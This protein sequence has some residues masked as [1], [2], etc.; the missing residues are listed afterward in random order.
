MK[1]YFW[2]L[3]SGLE[4]AFSSALNHR[5]S[6]SCGRRA[7]CDLKHTLLCKKEN[8][9]SVFIFFSSTGN[10]ELSLGIGT[11][12]SIVLPKEYCELSFLNQLNQLKGFIGTKKTVGVCLFCEICVV[13]K[14]L[15]LVCFV[16]SSLL[17]SLFS[18]P[19]VNW[20][21]HRTRELH[22]FNIRL[23]KVITF[24]GKLPIILM[25]WCIS[26]GLVYRGQGCNIIHKKCYDEENRAC[27]LCW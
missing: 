11:L 12:E 26:M 22:K 5:R 13:L 10:E 9:P 21:L 14:K 6:R 1:P 7:V 20:V 27:N 3:S 24:S 15:T 25:I 23:A 2:R 4:I 16:V 19:S 8:K 18:I 17:F